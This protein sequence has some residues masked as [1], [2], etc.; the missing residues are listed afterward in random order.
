MSRTTLPELAELIPRVCGND[1]A[2]HA[3]ATFLGRYCTTVT[4]E[5]LCITKWH[6]CTWRPAVRA[7]TTSQ[8]HVEMGSLLCARVFGPGHRLVSAWLMRTHVKAAWPV[9]WKCK[10]QLQA[11]L[12]EHSIFVVP[13]LESY[14]SMLPTYSH[15]SQSTRQTPSL[16]SHYAVHTHT[17]MHTH[18]HAH[19]HHTLYLTPTYPCNDIKRPRTGEF[20]TKTP[21]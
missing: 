20:F 4:K 16:Q 17:R 21:H 9:S 8:L 12:R 1:N 13:L 19:T 7:C 3:N 18:T 6:G 14:Y 15:T 10:P 2:Q 11:F 5:P